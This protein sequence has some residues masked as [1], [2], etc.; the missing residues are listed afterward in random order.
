MRQAGLIL[1]TPLARAIFK[2]VAGS[3][4]VCAL[5]SRPELLTAILVGLL[6][7][8]VGYDWYRGPRTSYGL[9]AIFMVLTTGMIGYLTESWGTSHGY[10]AYAGTDAENLVPFWVPVA[11][12]H[13]GQLLHS[14]ER[15]MAFDSMPAPKRI[16]LQIILG[17]FFPLLG[18]SICVANDVWQYVWP[19]K[20]LGIPALALM[21]ISWAHLA[22]AR[23]HAHSEV[24]R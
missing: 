24:A 21:L 3:L 4:V 22:F 12:A 20:I 8:Y 19:Y 9:D 10:W 13:A 2:V 6:A 15:G 17:M 14:L 18:E 7:L 5:H 16:F 1:K 11:W 23:M